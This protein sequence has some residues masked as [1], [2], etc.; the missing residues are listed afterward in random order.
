MKLILFFLFASM[1]LEANYC[2]QV[3]TSKI[4]EKNLNLLVEEANSDK[5]DGF[6]ALRIESRQNYLA[7]RLGE[8]EDYKE[9]LKDIVPIQKIH[10]NAYIRK[11]DFPNEKM[12]YMKDDRPIIEKS[13]LPILVKKPTKVQ[14][15]NLTV[16]KN[17]Q[18]Y[19]KLEEAYRAEKRGKKEEAYKLFDEAA[20]ECTQASIYNNACK[21]VMIYHPLGRKYLDDP[22]Y[23]TI[24]GEAVWFDRVYKPETTRQKNFTDVVYQ[25]K[26]KVGR[27]L[28]SDKK[29]SAYLF[30]HV[31]GDTNS[32]A[33]DIPII[34]SENYAGLGVGLDYRPIKEARVFIES[35][36]EHTFVNSGGKDAQHDYRVGV[37]Y[38]NQWGPGMNLSCS[39]DPT[40][41]FD[42]FSD[43]Y[44]AAVHYSRYHDNVIFQS[45]ARLGVRLLHYKMST[46][47]A[48]GR[49][50][51]TADTNSDFFNNVID[52]GPG[53]ELQPYKPLPLSIRTEYRYS[54][55]F[56][57][58]NNGDTDRFNSFLVYGVFYFEK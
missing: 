10:K 17:G 47:S 21:G 54:K 3:L 9:S 19:H 28:D 24:Y 31:D 53:L 6:G 52:I 23:A 49:L 30:A 50:G 51:I 46:L 18:A 2:I 4:S 25:I 44:L 36:I 1:S 14:K 29:T 12:L 22:Y 39:Y 41:P 13:K 48:Y 37:E 56:R 42:W 40:L 8:Y 16:T 32:K 15:Q 34:Y 45:A 33:G 43:L 27:Y 35:S 11:C 58:V 5:Y 57:K 55:Y 26:A 20:D 38:Y 7:F